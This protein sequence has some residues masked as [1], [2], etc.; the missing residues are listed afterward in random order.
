MTR[1]SA[2]TTLPPELAA[3]EL[4]LTRSGCA[5]STVARHIKNLRGILRRGRE[6]GVLGEGDPALSLDAET[7]QR[8]RDAV[9]NDVSPATVNNYDE[10]F[11]VWRPFQEDDRRVILARPRTQ[12]P[13][14]EKCV[15]FADSLQTVGGKGKRMIPLK[16]RREGDTR[17]GSVDAW[18]KARIVNTIRATYK[19]DDPDEITSSHVEK[20]LAARTKNA[21]QRAAAKGV[22]RPDKVTLSDGHWSTIVTAVR[23]Y[24]AFAEIK[25][26]TRKLALPARKAAVMP[27]QDVAPPDQIRTA[28]AEALA[29]MAEGRAN[30]D[31]GQFDQGRRFSIIIEAGADCAFRI[32][33]SLQLSGAPDKVFPVQTQEGRTVYRA[34]LIPKY[35]TAEEPVAITQSLYERLRAIG[36]PLY[37]PSWARSTSSAHKGY[38]DFRNWLST[39]GCEDLRKTHGMRRRAGVDKLIDTGNSMYAS[40]LL[41]HSNIATTETYLS[42]VR[43]EGE[44]EP[45]S[46]YAADPAP[47]VPDDLSSLAPLPDQVT[48][49]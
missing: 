30:G 18:N 24:A 36:G 21:Q 41:R 46:R 29:M 43:A 9:V 32:S 7:Y 8:I 2:H 4:W 26:P 35:R 19:L 44:A 28:M 34:M 13:M 11:K 12:T 1:A 16:Y 25:D 10:A 31:D 45:T 14:H 23:D 49:Q 3:L 39:I 27:I 6:T 47:R 37:P 20:Y 40:Q 22:A 5:P 15:E 38:R 33:E 42:S 17:S 48:K